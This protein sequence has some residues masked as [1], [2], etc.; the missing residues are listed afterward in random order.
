MK[1]RQHNLSFLKRFQR[2]TILLVT[3]PREFLYSFKL[4]TEKKVQIIPY[5]PNMQ[6]VAVEILQK[7]TTSLPGLSIHFVGSAALG[8]AGMKDLDFVIEGLRSDFPIYVPILINSFGMPIKHKVNFVEWKLKWR[9]YTLE[10]LLIDPANKRL[11]LEMEAYKK[12]QQNKK[13]RLEYEQLKL[14]ANDVSLREYQR[15][16]LEFYRNRLKIQHFSP[17][18]EALMRLSYIF[19]RVFHLSIHKKRT[20]FSK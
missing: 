1:K 16:K 10:L 6:K 9:K 4:P 3:C 11:Q 18:P 7:L 14:N 15:R 13:Y 2:N 20:L 12:L 5:D 19:T 17:F 8:I